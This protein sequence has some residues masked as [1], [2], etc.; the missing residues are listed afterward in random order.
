MR[1]S[2]MDSK[3]VDSKSLGRTIF[4][5]L[6]GVALLAG[7]TVGSARAADDDED[8]AF[9][10][11]ILRNILRSIGLRNG[12]EGGIDYRER[13]PLVVPPSR[14]LPAPATKA[15][16]EKAPAWP[17]DQDVKRRK[18]AR[19]ASKDNRRSIDWDADT[20]PMSPSA[21][22]GSGPPTGSQVSPDNRKSEN[23][24]PM[25]PSEL[26]YKGG[27][28][29]SLFGGPKE[30]YTTFTG[31]VPRS[32]LIEPPTGYRTPSPYQPYGVGREKWVPPVIDRHEAVR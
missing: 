4:G 19:A 1:K 17:T 25:R 29:S 26:G 16:T 14:N 20:R 30:E 12:N 13:S 31:E 32:N 23:D 22:R 27:L 15:A 6:L 8:V 18:E 3:R 5:A 2:P 11:K 24:G 9:D 21:L 7:S 10:T 28:F